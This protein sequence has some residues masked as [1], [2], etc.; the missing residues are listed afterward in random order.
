MK[1]V[2][3]LQ[4]GGPTAVINSS[5]VGVINAVKKNK[6]LGNVFGAVNGIEGVINKDIVDL[7]LLKKADLE[8][9]KV[10]PS[11]YLGT[12][13][14]QLKDE[15]LDHKFNIVGDYA[16]IYATIK[17]YDIGYI[18]MIGGNDSMDTVTK[19]EAF[20]KGVNLPV[21]IIGVPKTIDND[22]VI[23]DH[24]PG[25]GSALKFI[26]TEI[27]E[28]KLDTSSYDKGRVTIVEVM[29]RDA[30]WLTAGS[31]LASLNG[32][33]PD[34]IYMP[35]TPFSLSKFLSDVKKVYKENKKALVVVSEGLKN[36]DGKYLISNYSYNVINDVFGHQQLGGT[37]TVLAQIVKES[38][39][40]PVR[41]MELNL[42]Q[43][44]AGHIVSK[45]D[46]DEA[47]KCGEFAVEQ[48]VTESGK[49][50]VIIRADKNSYEIEYG[51]VAVNDIA[52]KVKQVPSEWI[53]NGNDIS[54]DFVNYA[55]PLIEGEV[56]RPFLNGLPEYIKR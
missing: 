13:R 54:M 37:C 47:Y 27:S 45:R 33:G 5:L 38:L 8:L 36:S 35:E 14:Y 7:N 12:S 26:A 10:T 2:L 53:L 46:L 43:R 40:I 49:A 32:L 11:A 29:G 1:N 23:T 48:I 20:F 31:K 30:G 22:M 56:E 16:H 17:E 41:S 25:Y 39:N 28:I 6:D 50:V 52:N 21:N 51:L 9:L 24:T 55:L 18:L 3:V 4:S 15:Y 34:L 42:S 19:L 44:C